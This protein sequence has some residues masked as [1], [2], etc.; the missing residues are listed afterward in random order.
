VNAL[1]AMFPLLGRMTLDAMALFL[2]A[3]LAAVLVGI[4]EAGEP[5]HGPTLI[6][7]SVPPTLGW[8]AVLA[9][10][11]RRA[12]WRALAFTDVRRL[13][14]T[15]LLAFGA[16]TAV[17]VVLGSLTHW[18]VATPSGPA[19]WPLLAGALGWMGMVTLRGAARSLHELRQTKGAALPARRVLLAGAGEA[20]SL[21]ARSMARHPET[22]RKAVGFVD[23]DPGKQ[24]R[25]I[26]GLPVLASI[27]ELPN[28][29]VR[30]RI[31]EVIITLPSADGQAVRRI[32]DAVRRTNPTI[33][34]RI[35]P[36][37][38]ELVSGQASI[39]RVREV[40]LE[41]LLRRP[42]VELQE[43]RIRAHL[44]GRR[45][46]VTGAGGSIGSEL[47]RQ[48][49]RFQPEEIVLLGRG[50]NSIYQL[51]RDLDANWPDVAYRSF[52]GGVQHRS[53]LR[54][55]LEEAQPSIVFHA[56]AHKHVPLMEA[57]PEEA[58]FNNV[59]GTRNLVDLARELGVA[60][61][62]NISTDKAVAP[63]SIMGA[64]KRMAEMLVADAAARASGERTFV[65]VRFGNVL[66][67]RGSVLPVFERQIAAGGPVTV[68]HPD[69]V[70]YFMTIPEATQ[71]VLQAS[72]TGTNGALYILDMGDPVRVVDMARDLI[73]LSGLE[74]DVDIKIH[75]SGAR[76]G[77]KLREEL[78]EDD[79]LRFATGH[80]KIFV[81]QPS[82]LPSSVLHETVDA[83]R[84]AAFHAN[85]NAIR[86]VFM[87][88]IDGAQLRSDDALA[89]QVDAG[90]KS[91]SA[92]SARQFQRTGT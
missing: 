62:V 84:D 26:A 1:R 66:G 85:Q 7:L 45:V 73:R 64:S 92:S 42:P 56:A 49:C 55:V 27:D 46:L 63:T 47:V 13:T 72:A 12:S 67:S 52:I 51:E 29:L 90:R 54:A 33:A 53:R 76:P 28:L 25:T 88:A 4:L 65:S 31:D 30:E 39:E 18:L 9:S 78:A 5:I 69:M 20:G 77:E 32:V 83:L 70:R 74:P 81:T 68:T 40:A 87:T 75:F 60:H 61:F 44:E 48:I 36:P 16:A 19:A 91:N 89:A 82:A 43:D 58:V 57:N 10:D 80:E 6:W 35:I 37:L 38:H 17:W 2:G 24:G 86:S 50:E 22:R 21:L 79:D 59:L 11:A 23:D 41:D 34:R 15:V 3:W 71:L 8:I 14:L